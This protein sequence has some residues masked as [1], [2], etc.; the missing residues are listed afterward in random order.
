MCAARRLASSWEHASY[1]LAARI[2]GADD[3]DHAVLSVMQDI[4]DAT[5]ETVLL[6]T[7]T[8]DR[9]SAIYTK[10]IASPL[11]VR[12]APEVG[13]QRPLYASGVGKLLLAYASPDFVESYLRTEDLAPV[14]RKTVSTQ[15]KLLERFRQIRANG[16][17]VSMDELVEGG[18]AMVAPIF[19][20]HGKVEM[21]LVI[22]APTARLLTNKA[23]LEHA[24]REGAERLSALFGYKRDGGG[25]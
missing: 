8:E 23:V 9:K 24:V 6:G 15:D 14:T 18:S 17:A 20:A 4:I 13:G 1:S 25:L 16:L 22:A 7:F 2:G 21:A 3:L 5:Q 19:N 12:F 10:R 11:P